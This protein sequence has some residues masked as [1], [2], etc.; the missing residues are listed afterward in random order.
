MGWA[1]KAGKAG[2]SCFFANSCCKM[3]GKP[4]LFSWFLAGIHFSILWQP[5]ESPLSEKI[6]W[7]KF[8]Q[9]CP[10]GRFFGSLFNFELLNFSE[11][12][13]HDKQTWYLTKNG[14]Q[15]WLKNLRPTFW[16]CWDSSPNYFCLQLQFLHCYSD[17]FWP[18]CIMIDKN[19]ILQIQGVNKKRWK[20]DL[21]PH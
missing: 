14:S 10:N 21:G 9:I 15:L 3:S 12:L 7:P 11:I 20:K 13:N 4:S 5:W 2:K 18:F 16:P 19:D 8:V 6:I 1:G 17:F